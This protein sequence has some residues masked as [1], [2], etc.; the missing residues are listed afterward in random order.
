[1]PSELF[2][3][4]RIDDVLEGS[5][6][7]CV[8]RV[9]TANGTRL[10][11]GGAGDAVLSSVTLKVYGPDESELFASSPAVSAVLKSALTV[12]GYWPYDSIGYNWFSFVEPTDFAQ[13]GGQVVR[14][15]YRLV[16]ANFGIDYVN[17]YKRFVSEISG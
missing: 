14:L 11:S 13:V 3:D 8:D 10:L 6:V 15:E 12:D 4:G 5:R 16:T 17:F 9:S 7:Y 1:M 2:R